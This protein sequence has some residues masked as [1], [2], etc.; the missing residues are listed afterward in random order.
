[1]Q[2]SGGV[3]I[4]M[5]PDL[6]KIKI[7]YMGSDNFK[8]MESLPVLKLFD[9]RV[10]DFLNEL[11]N[12]IRNDKE[13]KNYPDVITFGFFCRKANIQVLKKQYYN[14]SRIGRGVSFHIAPANVPIN[15]AYSLVAGLLAG[16]PCI[17]RASSKDFAQ[18]GIIC[19]LLQ[20]IQAKYS[21]SKYVAVISYEHNKEMTDYF[22]SFANIRAIWGG[23]Y[24]IHEIRKSPIKPR[25]VELSFANRYSFCVLRAAELLEM[26][27]M[28]ELARAFY[29]DTYLYDQNACSS[30]R[31][32]YWVGTQENIRNAKKIF[33]DAIQRFMINRYMVEPVIAVD[34]LLTGYKAAIELPG[35]VIELVQNN[36]IQRIRV[37]TFP[38]NLSDYI[39]PGGSFIEY[40]SESLNDL[41][42]IITEEYQTLIYFGF[43]GKE[44]KKWVIENGLCGIDRIVPIGKAVD[45]SLT[46]DG[47]NLIDTMSRIVDSN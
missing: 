41:M 22:S 14:E 17:V 20:G 26:D 4:L 33:W 42:P 8:N 12:E 9:E 45:F 39:C 29:N 28:E 44:L 5:Q 31:L 34:K 47:L 6:N 2:K 37:C 35:T 40:D 30:P 23:D 21:I 3:V 15:F 19:R 18:T 43:E 10:C 27:K 1:M 13:A 32:I 16:N 25:C 24:T 7:Y 46:W 36:I 38:V 11:S